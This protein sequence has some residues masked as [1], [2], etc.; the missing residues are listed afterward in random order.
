MGSED[1][2]ARVERQLTRA[3]ERGVDEEELNDLSAD[4]EDALY[5]LDIG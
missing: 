3:R 5:A 4:Y 1:S 2:V